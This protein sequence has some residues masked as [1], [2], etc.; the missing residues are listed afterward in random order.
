MGHTIFEWSTK[1]ESTGVGNHFMN[2][3]TKSY[4]L[5][6]I[7]T[8]VHIFCMESNGCTTVTEF[9]SLMAGG[10]GKSL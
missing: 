2:W 5:T 7:K 9:R 1:S 8:N 6:I 3:K 4:V 10:G